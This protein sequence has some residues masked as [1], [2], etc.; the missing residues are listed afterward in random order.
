LP[1]TEIMRAVAILD[2]PAM[3]L[4]NRRIHAFAK[5]APITLLIGPNASGKTL[6]L[7]ILGIGR[8]AKLSGQEAATSLGLVKHLRPQARLPNTL[9][10]TASSGDVEHLVYL[11]TVSVTNNIIH[12]EIIE[13]LA[14]LI[15][16]STGQEELLHIADLIEDYTRKIQDEILKLLDEPINA[17]RINGLHRVKAWKRALETAWNNYAASRGYREYQT[18]YVGELAGKWKDRPLEML[19][20]GELDHVLRSF[21]T[22]RIHLLYHVTLK[23]RNR[24]VITSVIGY[25]EGARSLLVFAP[26]SSHEP[27]NLGVTAYHPFYGWTN[28]MLEELY[29]SRIRMLGTLPG[30]EEAIRFLNRYLRSFEGFE[31]IGEMLHARFRVNGKSKRAPI[32]NLSDG[33]RA[34]LTLSL[35]YSLTPQTTLALIDT[36]EAFVHP[37]NLGL[38]SALILELARKGQVAIATQ[39]AELLSRILVEAQISGRLENVLVE[40]MAMDE[41]G[42]IRP[43]GVWDGE[44]ALDAIQDLGADLRLPLRRNIK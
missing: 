40:Q 37:D 24:P 41:T 29:E 43:T 8:A 21:E 39:S 17:E 31:I 20:E 32:Y 30:E 14:S 42:H 38:A 35:I 34:A 6:L 33:L 18:F 15:G 44:T 11:K 25:L 22:L 23:E 9:V 2:D 4:R 7:Q 3:P 27:E 5:L 16:R 19:T 1:V 13:N 28:G 26:P 12:Y 36:P 10:M